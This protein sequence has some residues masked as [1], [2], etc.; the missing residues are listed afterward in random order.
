MLSLSDNSPFLIEL[1][2]LKFTLFHLEVDFEISKTL[3]ILALQLHLF[4]I[5]LMLQVSFAALDIRKRVF[6]S[7][8]SVFG[9]QEEASRWCVNLEIKVLSFVLITIS[10]RLLSYSI[11]CV[12]LKDL[13]KVSMTRININ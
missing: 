7:F 11:I 13:V 6:S 8:I 10:S 12:R 9:L 2:F 3:F 1:F 5:S 4:S